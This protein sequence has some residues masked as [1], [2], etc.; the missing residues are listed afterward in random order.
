VFDGVLRIWSSEKNHEEGT[1]P[2]MSSLMEG[3][4]DG[5]TELKTPGL[6]VDF[7]VCA[8][9]T[10]VGT[11]AGGFRRGGRLAGTRLDRAVAIRPSR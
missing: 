2:R 11:T 8:R 10:P 9:A 1:V 7:T 5:I 4:R 6:G 3:D